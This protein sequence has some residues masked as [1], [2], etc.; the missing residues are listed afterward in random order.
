MTDTIPFNNWSQNRI[1]QGKK[2]CTS[3]HRRYPKDQRVY[4]ITPKLEWWFIKKF[5]WKAE[6]AT[7]QSELQEVIERIYQRKVDDNE[8]FYVHFGN[9]KEERPKPNKTQSE[10]ETETYLE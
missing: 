7:S 10:K 8:C 2:V 4:Y 5:L 6:G 1:E 3:R 9:F